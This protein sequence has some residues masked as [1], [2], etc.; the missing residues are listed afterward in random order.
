MLALI[1]ILILAAPQPAR[2][3]RAA[4][5]QALAHLKPNLSSAQV[6]KVLGKADRSFSVSFPN[7]HWRTEWDYG[8]TK[9]NPFPTLG[10]VIFLDDKL[11]GLSGDKGMPPP[12]SL[13]SEADLV[14]HMR[15]LTIGSRN[16]PGP[17]DF[18]R[19][20]NDLIPLGKQKALAVMK[21][22]DRVSFWPQEHLY[23]LVRVIFTVKSGY[24][25]TVPT[26]GGKL[27]NDPPLS[28][29]NFAQDIPF[30]RLGTVSMAGA[31]GSFTT[32]ADRESKDWTIRPE[33]LIM[34]NDPFAAFER[35]AS[36][37]GHGFVSYEEALEMVLGMVATA[38]A[39]SARATGKAGFDRC[40]QQY[41]TLKAYWDP[42]Q[43]CYVRG[44][45]SKLPPEKIG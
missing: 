36:S 33:R 13:I 41:L 23:W 12:K 20:A 45:G 11:V 38:Y 8:T 42:N 25:F 3:S 19:W 43:Q 30:L 2:A 6:E 31:P 24:V 4:F 14:H 16:A 35:V 29:V 1:P 44:D 5:Q 17:L 26:V 10:A 32:Y 7:N 37:D 28:P 9:E 22:S 15:M 39:P 40:H 18:V 34:P 27:S 21:E